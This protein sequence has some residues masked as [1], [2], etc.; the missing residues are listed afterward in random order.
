MKQRSLARNR[1]RR[2][3]WLRF[4]LQLGSVALVYSL[5]G[6]P[7]V[8]LFGPTNTGMLTSA[9]AG[10]LAALVVARLWLASDH[11]LHSAW[12][13]RPPVNL[14]RTLALA[15]SSPSALGHSC[16][17]A[18]RDVPESARVPRQEVLQCCIFESISSFST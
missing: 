5:A 7:P 8:L 12:N 13:I 6:V 14:P 15:A 1:W 17:V 9:V 4:L 3:G 2:L 18:L 10:M 16:F 11:A